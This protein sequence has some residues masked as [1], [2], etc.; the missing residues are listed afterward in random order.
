MLYSKTTQTDVESGGRE[1]H[2][3]SLEFCWEEDDLVASGGDGTAGPEEVFNF[4]E[5]PTHQLAGLLPHISL[6][7]PTEVRLYLYIYGHAAL[8]HFNSFVTFRFAFVY[9][10]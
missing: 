7:K 2:P 6:V 5:S 9:Y 3:G 4:D 8:T 1:F 10:F